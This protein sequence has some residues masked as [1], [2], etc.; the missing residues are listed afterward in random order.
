MLN[1]LLFNR[2]IAI[3]FSSNM[4]FVCSVQVY[5]AMLPSCR[6]STHGKCLFLCL[7]HVLLTHMLFSVLIQ[8]YS[9]LFLS[10]ACIFSFIVLWY[11][12]VFILHV[13]Q[14]QDHMLFYCTNPMT[15]INVAVTPLRDIS[16]WFLN[17][18]PN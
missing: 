7:S 15:F 2:G 13:L 8:A 10:S 17:F 14:I 4:E 18:L 5:H 6:T 12:S 16:Q 9:I 3:M 11:S 1:Y